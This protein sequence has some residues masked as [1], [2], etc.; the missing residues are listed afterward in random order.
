MNEDNI[1]GELGKRHHREGSRLLGLNLSS[2]DDCRARERR[3]KRVGSTEQSKKNSFNDPP[4]I[5]IRTPHTRTEHARKNHRRRV[6]NVRKATA[7]SPEGSTFGKV[8]RLHSIRAHSL[9]VF[10]EHMSFDHPIHPVPP[11]PRS[12]GKSCTQRV[13]A[14]LRRASLSTRIEQT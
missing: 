6:R 7:S 8:V 3:H 12:Q 11:K 5:G 4:L 2:V 1:A 13:S 9:L 14:F 10:S